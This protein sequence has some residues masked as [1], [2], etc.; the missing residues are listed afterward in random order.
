MEALVSFA[1]DFTNK[2]P[3]FLHDVVDIVTICQS[4]VLIGDSSESFEVQRAVS[5]INNLLPKPL[6]GKKS[7]YY[8]KVKKQHSPVKG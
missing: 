1:S 6:E 2:N 4:E 8:G 3:E 7:H 5:N